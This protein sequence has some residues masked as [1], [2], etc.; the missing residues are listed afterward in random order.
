MK[1]KELHETV[2]GLVHMVIDGDLPGLFV[3]GPGG[4]GKSH[5]VLDALAERQVAAK[6]LNTHATS[7]GLYTELYEVRD[8][9]VVLL[10]DLEELYTSLPAL[11]LLRGLLWGPRRADGSMRRLVTWTS[12]AVENAEVPASFEFNAGIV[13]T[14]NRFP[15]KNDVFN[16]LRTRVAVVRFDVAADEVF[17]FMREMVA[18]GFTV[19]DGKE[20]RAVKLERDECL[21]VVSFLEAKGAADLRMLLHGLSVYNRH[22]EESGW[23]RFLEAIVSGT[24]FLPSNGRGDDR[25]EPHAPSPDRNERELRIVRELLSREELSARARVSLFIEETGKSR[26]TFFRRQRELRETNGRSDFSPKDVR[27]AA[28]G[29]R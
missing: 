1:L 11:S 19:F 26:E 3:V 20:R 18:D 28:Y 16:S 9:K 5:A 25:P 27:N 4:L 13:M 6:T 29:E 8:E 2:R 23:R 21:E 12:R 24:T 7:F 14:A 22:R 17:A 10:E 15:A